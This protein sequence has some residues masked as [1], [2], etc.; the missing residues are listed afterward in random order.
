MRLS[1]PTHRDRHVAVA[2]LG[3]EDMSWTGVRVQRQPAK[4]ERTTRK[5]KVTFGEK[6]SMKMSEPKL[7]YS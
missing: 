6:F 5:E 2:I 7:T 3:G 1:E 4:K